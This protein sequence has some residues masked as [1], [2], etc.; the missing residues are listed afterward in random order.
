MF[1]DEHVMF[2]IFIHV[3]NSLVHWLPHLGRM[4]HTVSLS[5]LVDFSGFE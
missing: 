5:K 1:M 3:N 2:L 4:K